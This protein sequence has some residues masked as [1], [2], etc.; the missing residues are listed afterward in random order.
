MKNILIILCEII[1]LSGILSSCD[2]IKRKKEDISDKIIAKFDA[3]TPDTRFNKKRFEEFFGFK[4]T[5]DTYEIYC[6][7]NQLGIDAS[8][9]FTFKCSQETIDK[10]AGQLKL[11]ADSGTVGLS[12]FN[13]PYEW[14]KMD[15]MQ[16]M[17]PYFKREGKLYWYLWYDERKG[18]AFFLT[19]DTEK[20]TPNTRLRPD[21]LSGTE[22]QAFSPYP[23]TSYTWVVNHN[24]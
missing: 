1:L 19:F 16:K 23:T 9:Y 5:P 15:E 4:P 12:G 8:Y 17:N 18:Q 21:R 20:R 11:K 14:W 13:A 3:E 22:G 7:S 2:K 10:I 24:L 6:Y